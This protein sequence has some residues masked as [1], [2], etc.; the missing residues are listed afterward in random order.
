MSD[1]FVFYLLY[2]KMVE[3]ERVSHYFVRNILVHSYCLLF[4]R[5]KH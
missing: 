3:Q 4:C 1:M 5:E 2:N